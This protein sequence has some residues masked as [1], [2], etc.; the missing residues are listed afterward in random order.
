MLNRYGVPD[1]QNDRLLELAGEGTPQGC[2]HEWVKRLGAD[3]EVYNRCNR[4][5]LELSIVS[6]LPSVGLGLPMDLGE[7]Y[8]LAKS[9]GFTE[10]HIRQLDIEGLP[11][12]MVCVMRDYRNVHEHNQPGYGPTP[13]AALAAAIIAA[14]DGVK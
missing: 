5:H 9:L 14:V 8:R 2:R 13:E 6:D 3:L 7:M 1:E 4:C 12:V 11:K 10:I